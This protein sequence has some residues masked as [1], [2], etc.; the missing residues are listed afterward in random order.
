ME[1]KTETNEAK[2]S[3]FT[4]EQLE[5]IASSLSGQVQQL[6]E[7]LQ[8]ANMF[9]IFKRL[10]YCFK[11]LEIDTGLLS[12]EFVDRCAKEIEELMAPPTEED[13]IKE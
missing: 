13:N 6:N 2:Q 12:P 1:E 3:K 4:Y 11:V 8:K 9:N 5:Q 7:Q 10:D